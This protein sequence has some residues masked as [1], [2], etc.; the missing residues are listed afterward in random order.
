MA[1]KVSPEDDADGFFKCR[2]LIKNVEANDDL[3]CLLMSNDTW[4]RN[5]QI[6][7]YIVEDC[8]ACRV[9]CSLLDCD[10]SIC[11]VEM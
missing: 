11:V 7:F 8:F 9:D 10:S 1:V 6:F 5:S 2:K 4:R 3:P